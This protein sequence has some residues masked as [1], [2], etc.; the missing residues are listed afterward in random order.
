MTTNQNPFSPPQAAVDDVYEHDAGTQPVQLF[1]AKGRVGRLRFLAHLMGSYLVAILI[2]FVAGLLEAAS[3]SSF[4][5]TLVT[6]AIGL[7]SLWFYF[8][9]TIKRSHDMD[10]SGRTS[11]LTFIPFAIFVWVFK[12]GQPSANRFGP[13]APPNTTGV[14]ILGFIAPLFFVIA[15]VGIIAAIALPAYQGYVKRAS[16]QQM[17]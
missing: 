13:P 16:Q 11:L 1:S 14:K 4:I 5:S 2:G 17:R 10:W 8:V 6:A 15:I 12:S 9:V 7:A 3:G